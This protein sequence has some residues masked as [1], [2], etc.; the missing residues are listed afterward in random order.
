M[1]KSREE[2]DPNSMREREESK[3]KLKGK[4]RG[5]TTKDTRLHEGVPTLK[6]EETSLFLIASLLDS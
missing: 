4:N 2:E 5:E 1:N 6:V 3:I